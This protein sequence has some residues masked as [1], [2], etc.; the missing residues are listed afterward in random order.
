ML[1]RSTKGEY[2]IDR[3]GT[4]PTKLGPPAFAAALAVF[5]CETH[6]KYDGGDHVIIVGRVRELNYARDAAA[7]E[8]LL[9]YRGRYGVVGPLKA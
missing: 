4:V 8:P 5:E 3:A 6:A 7:M 1:F 9:F 2:K